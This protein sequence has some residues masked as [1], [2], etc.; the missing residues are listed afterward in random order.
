MTSHTRSGRGRDLKK[1][2]DQAETL[3]SPIPRTQ[4]YNLVAC[5]SHNAEVDGWIFSNFM[6]IC[7]LLRDKHVKGDFYSCFP[8]KE[9]FEFLA[10]QATAIESIKFGYFGQNGAETLYQYT[11]DQFDKGD[12]W[13]VQVKPEEIRPYIENWISQRARLARSGDVVNII[14]D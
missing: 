7:M 8:V 10:K 3:G 9:H 1:A 2:L 12:R 14:L 13:W 6:G 5:T 11:K 4:S